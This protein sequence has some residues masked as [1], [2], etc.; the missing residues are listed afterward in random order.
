MSKEN[1]EKNLKILGQELG[2]NDLQFDEDNTC[3][4]EFDGEEIFQGSSSQIDIV[5]KEHVG[6]TKTQ[7]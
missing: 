7:V 2:L 4:L 1:A 6:Q 5:I 3:V